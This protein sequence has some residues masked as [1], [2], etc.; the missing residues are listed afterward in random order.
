M[1][2]MHWMGG[3]L[4]IA[5]L[6][7]GIWYWWGQAHRAMSSGASAPRD[8]SSRVV[9][10]I[11]QDS[12]G[13]T[14]AYW[15]DPMVPTQKFDRPGKSPFMDMQLEPKY[16]E[17][18]PFENK[19]DDAG[20]TISAQIRQNLG[21]RLVT[22]SLLPFGEQL[23]AVGRIEPDQHGYFVV[24]TRV[25]G[26]VERLQVRAVGDPVS[27]GQKIA[28]VYAPE[29]LA[30][31]QEYLALLAYQPTPDP[32]V[33]TDV[34]FNTRDLAQAARERLKLL[35]MRETEIVAITN[36]GRASARFGVFAPASGVVTELGVREGAQLLPGSSLMQI[37]DFSRV[38]LIAEIP[39]RDAGRLQ[40]G[41]AAD[42]QL[43]GL[44]EAV[45]KGRVSYFYP[46]LDTV[47]RTLQV[48]IELANPQGKLRA[49][50]FAN[51]RLTGR[52]HE[53]IAVPSEAVIETGMRKVVIVKLPGG[54]RPV[55]VMTGEVSAGNTEIVSG[56][57]EGDQ[58]VSSGQFLIDSEATLSGVLARLTHSLPVDETAFADG[59]R[60][61]DTSHAS[62]QMPSGTGQ[63]AAVDRT[64][65]QVTLAHDPIPVLGWPAMTMGFK[66]M[67]VQQLD[68]LKPGDRVRFELTSDPDTKGYVIAHL[69]KQT[70]PAGTIKG[71]E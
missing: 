53:A 40:I 55:E 16:L 60:R 36:S 26:F 2:R 13:K 49:G 41:S 17:P 29:L 27:K 57:S 7:A 4:L 59:S 56:L 5:L 39:E 62:A 44:P 71:Q 14:V 42:I 45:F 46:V 28:E 6:N 51:V 31:Q 20:V 38:W 35:G 47:S 67:D 19:G 24:Q 54:F 10:G 65:G 23:Q 63:V 48:R 21:I 64:G 66:V 22:A 37:T 1:K 43:Q 12:S 34:V 15:Y 33:Q 18:Q 52:Q 58:V 69:Y 68:A 30:A 9:N 50:M 25:P 3:I 70:V 8:A 32:A 61:H 11:V